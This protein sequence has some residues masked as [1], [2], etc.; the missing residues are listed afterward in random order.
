M[1]VLTIRD[2]LVSVVGER[3]GHYKP[4]KSWTDQYAVF[5]ETGAPTS[6]S[7]D[8]K[9]EALVLRGEIFYYTK[10]EYDKKVDEICLALSEA[11]V[12]WSSEQI[13]YDAELGQI[14]YQIHWEAACGAGEVYN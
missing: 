3:V 5:G 6:V 9:A 11:D 2:V 7:A 10:K 14:S 8:D 12:S 1:S 13:G 4:H